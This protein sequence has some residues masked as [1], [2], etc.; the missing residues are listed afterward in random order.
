MSSV[1]QKLTDVDVITKNR[2]PT[3]IYPAFTYN[4]ASLPVKNANPTILSRKTSADVDMMWSDI[5]FVRHIRSRMLG[6]VDAGNRVRWTKSL[7]ITKLSNRPSHHH[8]G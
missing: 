1:G 2:Q 3:K 7:N 5:F 4:D 8:D 6:V